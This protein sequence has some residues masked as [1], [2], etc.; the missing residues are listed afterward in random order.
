MKAAQAQV[1]IR[2]EWAMAKDSVAVAVPP[3]SEAAATPPALTP[4]FHH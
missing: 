4:L 2:R 3:G 1:Q